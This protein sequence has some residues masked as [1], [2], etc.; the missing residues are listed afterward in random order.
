MPE[1]IVRLERLGFRY[2]SGP[3]APALAGIDLRLEAGECLLVAGA[4]G[5]GK[6]TLCRALNGLLPHF[7]PGEVQGR[8]VVA[9]L[10]T[11]HHPVHEL[12]THV[13][14]VFQNAET[15]LFTTSVAHELAFGLESLGLP[16]QE[17]RRRVAA[18]AKA[19]G[20]EPH[21]ARPPHSLSQ[22]EMHLVAI[23][24]AVAHRPRLLVLDEPFAR[25]DAANARL[26]LQA[27]QRLRQEGLSL[28]LTEHRLEHSRRLAD[29]LAVLHQGRLAAEGPLPEA[30]E[31][32]LEAYGLNLP[33]TVRL[34]RAAGL[35]PLPLAP[36]DWPPGSPLP[37]L[38]AP[39]RSPGG[40]PLITLEGVHFA[41]GDRP[42]LQGVDL[43][44]RQGEVLAILG[45]NG[46]GK[47]TLVRHLNGLLRPHRGRVYVLGRDTREARVSELAGEVA[48]VFENPNHQFFTASV[49]QELEVGPR[50]LGR[51]DPAWIEQLTETFRLGDLLDRP[52]YR[53]SEG[54]KK[55]VAIAAA[56]AG[57]PQVLVLDEPTTGQDEPAR[58]A[59][60][61]MFQRMRAMGQ[62][63]VL[64]THDLAFAEAH[65]DRWALLAEGRVIR[66]GA[67]EEVQADE[68]ALAQA[69]LEPTERFR[70]ARV[71]TGEVA[72]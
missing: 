58:R 41:Y 10:D 11:R 65:A 56:L 72:R 27:L 68:G 63:V 46:S 33:P 59:L 29:R 49:R 39:E 71:A 1:P 5:S 38:P 53:L 13:G 25:L 64:V 4:S 14:L 12:F 31:Q 28:V 16:P 60:G 43:E 66:S 2:R 47:S 15:Q 8:T 6:S 30:L 19:L 35:R 3:P 34:A 36:E 62:T 44:I 18:T 67:P 51:L 42:V 9:G 21:L 7:H 32:D 69:G 55:R 23:A 17:I 22:G 61:A 57:R 54:E 48:L 37:D 45:R 24:A 52:P 70:L 26:V 40:P 20:L 50:A